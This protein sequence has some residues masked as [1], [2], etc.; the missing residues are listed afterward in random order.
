LNFDLAENTFF[1]HNL[2]MEPL[3]FMLDSDTE[4][5]FYFNLLNRIF[6]EV[7]DKPNKNSVVLV[8][9]ENTTYFHR[10]IPAFDIKYILKTALSLKVIQIQ[11]NI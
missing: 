4:D 3:I 10:H 7:V 5:N 11:L 2:E 9:S 6:A 8:K 1:F